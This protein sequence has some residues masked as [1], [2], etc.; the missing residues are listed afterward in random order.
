MVK[1]VVAVAIMAAILVANLP[2]TK[3]LRSIAVKNSVVLAVL[4]QTLICK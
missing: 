3:S 1:L 4:R 2:P